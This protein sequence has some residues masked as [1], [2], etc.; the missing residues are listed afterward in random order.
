MAEW[1]KSSTVAVVGLALF[2]ILQLGIPASQVGDSDR[3]QRFGWQMFSVLGERI[4]FT[5]LTPDGPQD[6]ELEEVMARARGD[7]PIEILI[8]PHLCDSVE[9]AESITWGSSVY[10]C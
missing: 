4:T 8:P 10:E 2:A 9:G 3:P 6:M 7:I 5:V 1:R